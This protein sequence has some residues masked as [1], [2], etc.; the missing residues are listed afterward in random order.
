MQK[1]KRNVIIALAAIVAFMGVAYALLSQ[2]LVINGNSKITSN[3]KVEI[4]GITAQGENGGENMNAD[5]TA[6][7]NP[8]FDAT[9]ATFNASL[10]MPGSAVTYMVTIE[11]KGS[12]PAILTEDPNLDTVN[13]QEP[14]DVTYSVEYFGEGTTTAAEQGKL[15]P[16]EVANYM[17]TV[18]WNHGATT[19]P[20]TLTKSATI[21]FNY[22]QDETMSGD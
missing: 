14:T 12:V 18:E 21:T 2:N 19:I 17:V 13:A 22:Q 4:T 7:E 3:W 8:T 20:E 1:K 9:S 16:G 15:A 5:F 6:P 10:P 11:N